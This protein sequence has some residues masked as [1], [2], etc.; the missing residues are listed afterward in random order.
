M[1]TWLRRGCMFAALGLVAGQAI[2]DDLTGADVLLCTSVKATVCTAAADCE[3]GPPWNLNIPQF[4]RIDLKEKTLG[5][6][7]ASAEQRVT[8]LQS[9]QRADG[10]IVLQGLERGRAFSF[11]IV[12]ETGL[13]SAA[14]A[15]DGIAVSVFGACT[16]IS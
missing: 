16:P 7:A 2:A 13:L 8:D 15:R 9:V 12:E 11:M 4:L 10:T 14:V 3:S 6:T 1:N 5:T